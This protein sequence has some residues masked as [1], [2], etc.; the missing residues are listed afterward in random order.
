MSDARLRELERRFEQSRSV[1]DEA[2]LIYERL[3]VGAITAPGVTA[4]AELVQYPAA[5]LALGGD[6]RTWQAPTA[7]RWESELNVISFTDGEGIVRPLGMLAA[8][9]LATE[10]AWLYE[11]QGQ[12]I[13][14]AERLAQ[15]VRN[16]MGRMMYGSPNRAV[17]PLSAWDRT[18]AQQVRLDWCAGGLEYVEPRN[19]LSALMTLTVQYVETSDAE[20][21]VIIGC[22]LRRTPIFG[23]I[24][25]TRQRWFQT[26]MMRA[27]LPHLIGHPST[28]PHPTHLSDVV[29][30]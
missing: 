25:Q 18:D 15:S 9:V 20:L 8:A 29:L 23:F 19:L 14:R 21:A 2:A 30:E 6:Q 10:A 11:S 12:L 24:Q 27:L 26:A 4:A 5:R 16:I 3:R 13:G 7:Q 17:Q 28:I 1:E 22:F